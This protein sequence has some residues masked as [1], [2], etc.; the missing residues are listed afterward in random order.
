MRKKTPFKSRASAFLF[1]PPSK[2]DMADTAPSKWN[3]KYQKE[4]EEKISNSYYL[5]MLLYVCHWILTG[6]KKD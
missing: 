6:A 1:F 2:S 5:H 3:N 4:L